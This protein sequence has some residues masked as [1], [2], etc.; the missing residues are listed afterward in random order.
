[1]W[2]QSLIT[3]LFMNQMK[4]VRKYCFPLH[5]KYFQRNKTMFVYDL[6]LIHVFIWVSLY[7]ARMWLSL[8]AYEC[9]YVRTLFFITRLRSFI[10]QIPIWIGA[11]FVCA[12]VYV[13]API[14]C[15]LILC[16]SSIHS[17][18]AGE[19]TLH[20]YSRTFFWSCF[21]LFFYSGG[22]CCCWKN[23]LFNTIIIIIIISKHLG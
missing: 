5:E 4:L 15:I 9:C 19:Y 10:Y 12:S 11:Q 21:S 7:V 17:S 8:K 6:K 16:I 1:M 3:Y 14:F 20:G 23:P 13:R 2:L 22:V 18:A